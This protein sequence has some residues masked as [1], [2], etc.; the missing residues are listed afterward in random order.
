MTIE[1]NELASDKNT[2]TT[3]SVNLSTLTFDKKLYNLLWYKYLTKSKCLVSN[4]YD[5]KKISKL[6]Q[7]ILN[8][9]CVI[10]YS[11]P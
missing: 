4:E 8:E 9:M 2:F 3:S 10:Y 6:G 7:E 5:T 11:F 1:N